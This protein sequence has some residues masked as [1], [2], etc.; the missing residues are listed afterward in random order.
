MQA[1]GGAGGDL[2]EEDQSPALLCP[3]LYRQDLI[4]SVWDSACVGQTAPNIRSSDQVQ[5]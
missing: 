3:T 4:H 5:S 1:R 2:S